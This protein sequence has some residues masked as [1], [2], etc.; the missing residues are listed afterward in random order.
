MHESSASVESVF[1]CKSDG[2]RRRGV[3]KCTR[4]DY[5]SGHAGGASFERTSTVLQETMQVLGRYADAKLELKR[6]DVDDLHWRHV[7]GTCHTAKG[8]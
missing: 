8:I 1:L 7:L 3:C 6:L 4:A 5:G 2:E